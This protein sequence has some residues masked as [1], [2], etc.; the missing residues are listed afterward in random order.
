[1]SF[2]RRAIRSLVSLVRQEVP[3]LGFIPWWMGRSSYT[4]R[5]PGGVYWVVPFN[6]VARWLLFGWVFLRF[7]SHTRW[8]GA[9]WASHVRGRERGYRAGFRDG[10]G[11]ARADMSALVEQ[12]LRDVLGEEGY[13]RVAGKTLPEAERGLIRAEAV[14]SGLITPRITGPQSRSGGSG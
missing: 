13:N 4:F 9:L 12:T 14:G 10:E 2:V 8:E 7:P 6:W 3:D 1:M 11:K 5:R